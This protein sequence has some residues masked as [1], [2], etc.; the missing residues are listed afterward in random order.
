MS[1]QI[2]SKYLTCAEFT[3]FLTL[4]LRAIPPPFSRTGRLGVARLSRK[5]G[6]HFSMSG[7]EDKL[8]REGWT[9]DDN[10]GLFPRSVRYMWEKMTVRKEQFYV[11]A[12]F[13]EIYNEQLRD[14]LNPSSGI[15]HCRW[16]SKSGFFV[17]DLLVVECTSQEDLIA[18]LHEG[19]R[20]RKSGSHELNKDSS[21][22]HSI[23]TVYLISETVN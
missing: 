22:S 2:K 3:N 8:G 11:K 5:F 15:L 21:R 4:P 7:V 18:V 14:L 19:L 1:K 6:A 20:N 10:D 9:S 23:L 17:E 12:S 16:N 13:L